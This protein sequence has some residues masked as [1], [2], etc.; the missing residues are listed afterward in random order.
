MADSVF[1]ERTRN[2]VLDRLRERPALEIQLE[3]A[4][5]SDCKEDLTV[6]GAYN[7]MSSAYRIILVLGKE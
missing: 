5:M 7:K 1:L 2:L 6:I 3:M 4:S